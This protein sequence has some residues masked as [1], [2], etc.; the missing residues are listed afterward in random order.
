[1]P[2]AFYIPTPYLPSPERQAS[3]T[4]GRIPE[5]LGGG[6]AASAQSWLYQTWVELRGDCDVR[7]VS[8]LPDRGVVI[9][10]S[11]HL[12]SGF[13][14]RPG[15]FIAAVAADFLPHPGA[16]MQIVQNLAHARRLPG[17]VFMPHWPQ[18]NLVARDL[19]RGLRIETAAFF[20]DPS[21]LAPELATP[22]FQN[23]LLRE[24]GV[25]FEVRDPARWHDF[26]DVDV[27]VAIRDFSRARHLGK[28]ATK[29]YNAWLAG[30]PLI[31][32][33]DSA[34]SSE[35]TPGADYLV[36]R[37]PEELVNRIRSLRANP[38]QWQA[39]ADAGR[40]RTSE[41]SR[42]AVRSLWTALCRSAI[43]RKFEAW[44]KLSLPARAMRWQAWRW[45]YLWDRTFR[46]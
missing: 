28:P 38:Q 12:H 37:S 7:L 34:F 41:R 42:E 11:N 29:L 10:L 18:P 26:S 8:E 27:V 13:R 20:G 5:L 3:W 24:T 46:S 31:G 33:S 30:V 44:E 9:T 6:K 40:R 16:Q 21:N 14:A 36:A 39:I 43:P 32:G 35:A 17:A 1:M 19:S 22:A 25:T 4:S 2:I 23:H 15:Q 45:L